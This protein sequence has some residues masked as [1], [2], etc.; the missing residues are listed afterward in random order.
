MSEQERVAFQR[1]LT[2][3]QHESWWHPVSDAL[4]ERKFELAALLYEPPPEL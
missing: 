1:E 4:R 2:A 3:L